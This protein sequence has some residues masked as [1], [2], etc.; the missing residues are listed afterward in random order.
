MAT[1]VTVYLD[2]QPGELARLGQILG[3]A[4]VNIEGFC[5]IASAG[6]QAETH[7]LIED[8][9]VA[10]DALAAAGIEVVFE[11]EV[12]V[13]P[14]EDRPGEL[15]Q[16]SRKLGDA[17]VNITLAYLATSTRLVFAAD[18]FAKAKTALE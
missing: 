5:A 1:D 13:V 14:V 11:Q 6:G 3:E 18:D 8:A 15:G 4:G 9:A 2:D 12:A 17:G 10:F 16:V 7:V